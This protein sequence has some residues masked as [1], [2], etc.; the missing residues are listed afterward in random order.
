MDK[1]IKPLSK[2][3]PGIRGIELSGIISHAIQTKRGGPVHPLSNRSLSLAQI[4]Q[5]ERKAD[6]SKRTVIALF[7]GS[8]N[9]KGANGMILR[10]AV[11][12]IVYRVETTLIEAEAEWSIACLVE[13]AKMCTHRCARCIMLNRD[14]PVMRPERDLPLMVL[15]PGSIFGHRQISIVAARVRIN[16][17]HG[18]QLAD[19][20]DDMGVL[21]GPIGCTILLRLLLK[22]ILYG[23][24]MAAIGLQGFRIRQTGWSVLYLTQARPKPVVKRHDRVKLSWHLRRNVLDDKVKYMGVQTLHIDAREAHLLRV[25]WIGVVC[26]KPRDKLQHFLGAPGPFQ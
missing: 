10:V 13:L 17:H 7:H 20:R 23:A 9:G 6:R 24:C 22:Q 21:Q 8:A 25:A 3:A 1:Q 14:M 12:A 11:R 2:R 4:E 5:I 15:Q 26:S 18:G 16:A 19:L